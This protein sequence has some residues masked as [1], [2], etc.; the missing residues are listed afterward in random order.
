MSEYRATLNWKRSSADFTYDSYNRDHTIAVGSGASWSAS[1]AP[2]YKG[3]ATK[4]NPE[5]SLVAA[6]SSCHMLT[7]LAIAAKKRYVVDSYDDE[8][9]C[10]LGKDSEGGLSVTEATLRPRVVFGTSERGTPNAEEL[11]KLH[12]SAH[13]NCF[14][15]RSV[16]T[17]IT[18]APR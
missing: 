2:E 18:V 14:V 5:E 10:V 15:A 7:F 4:V 12:E 17:K 9:S 16:K 8:A 6:M 3:D 13:K 1:S 11:E